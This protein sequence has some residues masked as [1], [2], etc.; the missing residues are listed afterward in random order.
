MLSVADIRKQ[1]H[2]LEIEF[3]LAGAHKVTILIIQ[4]QG[5]VLK[6][7]GNEQGSEGTPA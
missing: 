6:R 4:Q 3:L 1:I 2:M 5:L 7:I